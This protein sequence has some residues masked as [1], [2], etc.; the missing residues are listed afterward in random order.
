MK[1]SREHNC[2]FSAESVVFFSKFF[3]LLLDVTWTRIE[4]IR[5][6]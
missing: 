6:V 4:K 1:Y 3:Y 5:I 2:G